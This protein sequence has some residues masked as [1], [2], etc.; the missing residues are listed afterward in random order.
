MTT[1]D[2]DI[3][4]CGAGPTG[5]ALA[6]LLAKNCLN[7]E[8]IAL[9]GRQPAG[10]NNPA[11]LRALALNF[12]SLQL[13]NSLSAN[14]TPAAKIRTVHISQEKHFGRALVTNKDLN[15][16][17]LGAVVG[18]DALIQQLHQKLVQTKIQFIQVPHPVT[19][20]PGPKVSVQIN[21]QTSLSAHL[22]VQSDGHQPKGLSHNYQQHAIVAT[23]TASKPKK[24]WAFERFTK[25]G[26]FALLPHPQ[27]L[28]HYALV[29][30]VTPEKAQHLYTLSNAKFENAA[31][32][33]FGTRMGILRLSSKRS[34][35]PLSLHAGHPLV[36]ENIVAIGNAAQTLHPVA[37]Q[38]LNLGLR[39]VAQLASSLKPWLIDKNRTLTCTLQDYARQRRVDRWL[40]I[41]ITDTLAKLFSHSNT[42]LQHTLGIGLL[43]LDLFNTPRRALMRHLL[44][45]FRT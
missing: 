16:P 41:G 25:N 4:I 6:L 9:I 15:V 19:A 34:I 18:Y 11:D 5:C 32:Q 13:L 1:A 28:N 38:G 21:Q 45:G 40:T 37:G 42:A 24:E 29:W 7:P 8:R 39:D 30:C 33:T 2:F 22:A 10:H 3:A 43:G 35:F 23:V 31:M 26:P 17:V 14:P 20:Q 44:Q 36:A 12:G 27:S